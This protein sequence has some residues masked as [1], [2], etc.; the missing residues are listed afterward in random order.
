M[1]DDPRAVLTERLALTPVH[2]GDLDPLHRINAD[3][4]GWAHDPAGRHLVPATT[5]EWIQR[6]AGRWADD[7]LSYWTVR[8]RDAPEV[9][10]IGG[11][12]LT[13]RGN[14]NLFY[15]LDTAHWGRGYATELS[16]AAIS[17]AHRHRP[18]LP[19]LAM[20]LPHNQGSRAVAERL[21]L[22]DHGLGFD[23]FRHE[24]AHLYADRPVADWPGPGPSA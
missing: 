12:Q 5:R 8:L 13:G 19:V 4:G 10:G 11:V 16:R 18:E 22:I 2:L 24:W 1:T 15:R 20:I 9:I 17:A 7:G 3:P 14:W 6:A 21:G 23:P